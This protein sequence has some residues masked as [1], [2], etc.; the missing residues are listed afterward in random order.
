[1]KKVLLQLDTDE[2]PSPFDAIVAHDEHCHLAYRLALPAQLGEVQHD[3]RIEPEASYVIAVRNPE[4]SSPP[5]VGL[6]SRAAPRY[7]RS[8]QDR[9]AG[10][11]F[12]TLDPAFLDHEGT[13]L[14]L[15]GSAAD[16]YAELGIELDVDRERSRETKLFT[17]L[18][19][20]QREHPIE[21]LV[22]GR[23]I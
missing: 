1:M 16:V 14:V 3:L 18:A 19:L 20:D 11:R 4:V 10:R 7:P 9:F 8:L 21:P 15:I 2:H 22:G 12:A 6:S 13:D 5:G 17:D 23:W